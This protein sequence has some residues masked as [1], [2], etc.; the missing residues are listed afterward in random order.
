MERTPPEKREEAIFDIV[1]QLNRGA[2][3]ITSPK[4]RAQVAELNVRAGKR[5]KASSAYASA[6]NYLAAGAALLPSDPWE[7]HYKLIFELELQRSECEFLTG[8]TAAEERLLKLSARAQSLV[9]FAA[10]TSLQVVLYNL[11]DRLDQSV[12]VGLNY[13]RKVGI[14]WT[15]HPTKEEVDR[16]YEEMSAHLESRSIE[17]MAELARMSDP[18]SYA[19]VEVLTELAPAAYFTDLEL[20]SLVACQIATVSFK[21]GNSNG[22]VYAYALLGVLVRTRFGNHTGGFRFGL[23]ALK[24]VNESGL[25]RF[26]ARVYLNFAY[27]VNPW[28]RHI[29]TGRP[30]LRSGLAAAHQTG[31]LTFAAYLYYCLITDLL[32]SGDPLDEAQREAETGLEFASRARYG[33]VVDIL[34]GHLGLIRALRGLTVS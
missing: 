5:A 9:D 30:L 19:T 23:L 4:E 18:Q 29:R 34:T 2:A 25:D 11:L 1:S 15:A 14:N 32:A 16:E 28:N 3:L 24:L 31:N 7:H 13:L 20:F 21:N 26:R 33:L 10:V 12:E 27:A 8:G 17:Q 22:S 6:L